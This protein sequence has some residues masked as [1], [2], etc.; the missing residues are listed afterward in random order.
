MAGIT[1]ARELIGSRISVCLLES[2]SLRGNR[3]TQKLYEGKNVSRIFKDDFSNFTSYLS[4]SRSRYFGGSSNCWGGWCR[5]FDEIDFKRRDWVPHSNGWPFA[6]SELMPYYATAHKVLKLGPF[7]YDPRFWQDAIGN[8]EF[9]VVPFNDEIVET[10]INQFSRPLRMGREYYDEIAKASTLTALLRANVVEIETGDDGRS[11]N[12]V[13]VATLAGNRFT[14]GARYFVLATGGIENARL[15]LASNKKY[16]RGLGNENDLVGRFFM[17]HLCVPSGRVIYHRV[18]AIGRSYDSLYNYNNP[19]FAAHGVPVATHFRISDREQECRRILNSRVS[20]RSIL[21][22]DEDAGVESL[23]NLYRLIK[24]THKVPPFQMSDVMNVVTGI[25]GI[26]RRLLGRMSTSASFVAEHRLFQTVEPAP[27]PDSRVML[28]SDRDQLGVPKVTL[29]WR[30]GEPSRH[31][32][33]KVRS[34]IDEEMRKLDIGFIEP[35][36]IAETW[37]SKSQWVWHHMGTTRMDDDPKQGVVDRNVRMH[38][39]D[40]LYVAGSSVFPSCSADE[41]TLTIIALALRLADHLKR[42]F[43]DAQTVQPAAA[44]PRGRLAAAGPSS[45]S[46]ALPGSRKAGLQPRSC[47]R[48]PYPRARRAV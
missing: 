31:T 27:D 22:G 23:R 36:D 14:V 3:A 42:R 41:P 17:E 4:I 15:L 38:H 47:R 11:V 10:V 40:N 25:G 35:S 44:A 28:G 20:I 32:M 2:G 37:P 48:A 12:R 21:I 46:H 18:N 24:N 16:Q 5:P 7:Q 34:L 33:I 13:Q 8:S 43:R 29:D 26:A 30:L 45:Q 19:K 9:H 1:I 6:K 39:I